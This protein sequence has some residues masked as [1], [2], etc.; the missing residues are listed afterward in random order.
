MFYLL[1][2]SSSSYMPHIPSHTCIFSHVFGAGLSHHNRKLYDLKDHSRIPVHNEHQVNIHL[3]KKHATIIY[4]DDRT[5]W[6]FEGQLQYKSELVCS[7]DYFQIKNNQWTH[8]KLCTCMLNSLTFI[9]FD[10]ALAVES[11]I[12]VTLAEM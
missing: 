6:K 3:K 5:V 1:P 2:R 12:S 10:T 4:L 7:W 9:V 8:Y 11:V